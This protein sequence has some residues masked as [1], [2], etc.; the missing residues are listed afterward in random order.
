M[1]QSYDKS[2]KCFKNGSHDVRKTLLQSKSWVEN[3]FY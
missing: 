2:I 3:E 1:I